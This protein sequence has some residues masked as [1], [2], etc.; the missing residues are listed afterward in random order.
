MRAYLRVSRVPNEPFQVRLPEFG[1][2][3][4]RRLSAR[5][6]ECNCENHLVGG[7]WEIESYRVQK[8]N[9]SKA[10]CSLLRERGELLSYVCR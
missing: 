2:S 6:L 5:K 9:L 7:Y 8:R 1:P 3:E 4:K 10:A